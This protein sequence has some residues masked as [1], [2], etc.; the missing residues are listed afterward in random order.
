M[1]P[2]TLPFEKKAL[3]CCVKAMAMIYDVFTL[4]VYFIF[5]KPWIYWQR[6]R[7]IFAE[8]IIPED[9]SSPYRRLRDQELQNLKGL[10]TLD[11]VARK[12]I[13]ENSK[14]P[15]LGT[16]AVLGQ[17]EEKQA[18][19]QVSKKLVL[20]DYEWLTY[21]DVGRQIDLIARGLLSIGAKPRQYLAILAETR[22]EWFLT[23]QACFRA[24]I[25]LATLYAAL[26]DDGII[27]AVN[28]TEVTHLVT[29]SDLMPRLVRI[30]RKMPSLTH[31]IYMESAEHKAPQ[32][33]AQGPQ[34]SG[35]LQRTSRKR[36]TLRG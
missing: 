22:A 32:I 1:A 15:A 8:R 5:Q 34:D 11:E 31:I 23:A 33:L 24:N 18:S 35:V 10:Q 30:V 27:S 17:T 29:S 3:F 2:T 9:P 12:A 20:G 6:K 16:R 36:R 19:G 26:S 21:E 25:P 7:T 14:R 13:L 28:E 4:P